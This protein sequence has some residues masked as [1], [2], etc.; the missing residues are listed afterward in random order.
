M[1]RTL[2]RLTDEQLAAIA[3]ADA[4]VNTADL[5]RQL[6]A[7]YWTVRK[8][9]QRI[10]AAGGWQCPL[11]WRACDV[12]GRP[13]AGGPVVRLRH[14]GCQAAWARAYERRRRA[15]RAPGSLST[16]HVR[17]YRAEH[18]EADR[19]SRDRYAAR[20]AERRAAEWSEAERAAA[21]AKARAAD[22]RD[23]ALTRD[24][25][26]S[27]GAAWTAEDD[28]VIA[29]TI[30]QPARETA[31]SLGRTLHAVRGRRVWLRKQGL[32]PP[33]RRGRARWPD[34][35]AAMLTGDNHA[36]D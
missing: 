24:A 22:A 12:C 1:T 27:S 5:A 11:M 21:L 26:A 28:A 13:V 2:V 19:A 32:I 10:Q 17:R 3:F 25:A 29:A 4:A 31:L 30:D 20:L 14:A 6:D 18:P 34:G 36:T 8:A 15:E 35:E 7:P 23:Q 9:R 16:P 33:A